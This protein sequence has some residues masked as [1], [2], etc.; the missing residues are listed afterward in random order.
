MIRS[1]TQTVERPFKR[2]WSVPLRRVSLGFGSGSVPSGPRRP[3]GEDPAGVS[4]HGGDGRPLGG[5]RL[6]P[7]PDHHHRRGQGGQ[8][9][10]PHHPRHR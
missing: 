7:G 9:P 5:L 6:P 1:L 10:V 8:R 3:G 4:A 2:R